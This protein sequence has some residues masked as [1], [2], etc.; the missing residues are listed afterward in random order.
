MRNLNKT[1]KLFAITVGFALLASCSLFEPEVVE[2]TV[3]VPQTVV[4]TEVVEK[5]VTATVSIAT[6]TPLTTPI[7]TQSTQAASTVSAAEPGG[8]TPTVYVSQPDTSLTGD[9]T[10]QNG[11]SGWCMP[12]GSTGPDDIDYGRYGMPT[13]GRPGYVE[14]GINI[15]HIPGQ[16]CTLVFEFSSQI[17]SG[18]KVYVKQT[19]NNLSFYEVDLVQSASNPNV[20]Y[21]HLSH[22]YVVNPPLWGVSYIIEAVDGNGNTRWSGEVLFQKTQPDLCWDGSKPDPVTMWCPKEDW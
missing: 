13:N 8:T 17:G 18:G 16:Y 9:G 1:A 11:L 10:M 20:G 15:M 22:N 12:L 19:H 6:I 3:L 2:A 7:A 5:V 21:A 14:N 4:V